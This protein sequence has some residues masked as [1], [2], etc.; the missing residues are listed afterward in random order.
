MKKMLFCL[1]LLG[2]FNPARSQEKNYDTTA[3]VILDHMSAIVGD[4]S[5]CRFRLDT[6]I[7]QTDADFGEITNHEVSDISF[8]GPD[9]MVMDIRGDKGHRGYWYNGKTLTWYSFTENNF[10]VIDVPGRTVDMIDSVNETYGIEFPAADFFN[11]TLSDDLI[12][13]SEKISFQGKT[14]VNGHSCYQISAVNKEM[15]VQLWVADELRFLPLKMV[16]VYHGKTPVKR[17]EAAFSEWE[18][19][20]GLPGA[21]FEFAVPPGARQ[22]SILP[23]K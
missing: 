6:E 17:Y 23:K 22:V 15:T 2:L 8:S 9:K 7:D 11:P 4:L 1:F 5:S 3:I 19:N 12:N 10:V 18:I 13:L 20:P 16:I 21:I 14:T